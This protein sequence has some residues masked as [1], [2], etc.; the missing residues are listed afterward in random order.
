MWQDNI[1]SSKDLNCNNSFS[2]DWEYLIWAK[3]LSKSDNAK[4]Y[5]RQEL[6]KRSINT[7]Y[8]ED[9]AH[10]LSALTVQLTNDLQGIGLAG[11]ATDLTSVS[12]KSRG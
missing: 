9:G 3:E 10:S 8:Q 5:F 12:T 7:L 2:V 4:N 1:E 6:S 11:T